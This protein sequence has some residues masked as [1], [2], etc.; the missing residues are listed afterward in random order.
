MRAQ[1][2]RRDLLNRDRLRYIVYRRRLEDLRSKIRRVETL[3]DGMTIMDYEILRSENYSY[4]E[5]LEDR[6][7]DLEKLSTKY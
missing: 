4:K 3:G 7:K 5:K 2:L 6:E 1:I